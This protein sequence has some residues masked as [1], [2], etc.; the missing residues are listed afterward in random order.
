M[1]TKIGKKKPRDQQSPGKAHPRQSLTEPA[2]RPSLFEGQARHTRC[3][4]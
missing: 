4:M 2:Q 1:I 3:L